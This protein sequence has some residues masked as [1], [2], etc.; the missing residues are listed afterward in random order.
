M[1]IKSILVSQPKPKNDKNPFHDLA[2]K[3][4]LKVDF[5]SFIHV[6]GVPSKDF[7]QQRIDLSN[8]SAVIFTSRMAID[9]YFRMAKETRFTVPDQMKYF[10]VS[11]AVAYYLQN[12][13]VYRKRKI[14]HGKQTFKDLME[15]VVKHSGERYLVPCSDIQRKNIP[16]QLEKNQINF[17]NA[18]L[19]NSVCS[20]LSDLK[21]VKY[22]VLVF[23][24]PSGIQSLIKNFP[25]F[26]QNDTKI[27]AF[28]PTTVQAAEKA[29]LRIDIKAPMPGVPSMTMAIEK[30]IKA[31]KQPN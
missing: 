9:H 25:K 3:H 30:Y 14:F 17:K 22:D 4:A 27:A 8:Y 11:E 7:R 13:V 31:E 5:R 10:C 2:N 29:G 16:D 28:G 26:E 12:Y 20:D 24:S 21:D 15:L 18:T 23:Y 19:Y 6:E 1:N